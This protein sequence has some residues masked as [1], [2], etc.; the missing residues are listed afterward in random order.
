MK[1]DWKTTDF[2]AHRRSPSIPAKK[3]AG[4]RKNG[5]RWIRG[6]WIRELHPTYKVL[7]AMGSHTH[8]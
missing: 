7:M 5:M 3:L 6:R 2:V 8:F 1:F 4:R